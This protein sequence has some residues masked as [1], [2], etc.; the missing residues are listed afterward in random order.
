[1]WCG[2]SQ[3]FGFQWIIVWDL[4]GAS[5][6]VLCFWVWVVALVLG[7]CL[8]YCL[9]LGDCFDL[10]LCYG[11]LYLFWELLCVLVFWEVDILGGLRN[12]VTV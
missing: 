6:L 11:L 2:V 7:L 8:D 4:G 3:C 10:W 12:G 1:M 9:G 5:D